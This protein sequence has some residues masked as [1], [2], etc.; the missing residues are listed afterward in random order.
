M[1]KLINLTKVNAILSEISLLQDDEQDQFLKH[2]IEIIHTYVDIYFLKFFLLDP[3]SEWVIFRVGT[4]SEATDIMLARGYRLKVATAAF[5]GKIVLTGEHRLTY[6]LPT[7]PPYSLDIRFEADQGINYV[8][9]LLPEAR[10]TLF[11]PLRFEGKLVGAWDISSSEF[12]GFELDDI[13]YLQLLAD[14]LTVRLSLLSRE[15]S[16]S[17]Q[18]ETAP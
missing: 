3:E 2:V 5:V 13:V 11:L 16:L 10:S 9:P 4:S 15:R 8:S 14:Q 18:S 6:S 17:L 1:S 12:D 7:E